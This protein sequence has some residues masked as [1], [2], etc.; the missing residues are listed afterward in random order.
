MIQ[1]Y[2]LREISRLE[3]SEKR[4]PKDLKICLN[5]KQVLASEQ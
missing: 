2:S 5:N 4:L 3:V 1:N